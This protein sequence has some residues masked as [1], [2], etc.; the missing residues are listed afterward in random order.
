MNR[1]T[2]LSSAQNPR[3]YGAPPFTVAVVHGG[4]GAAGETAPAARELSDEFGVIEPLQTAFTIQGQ[5]EELGGM[6]AAYGAL[7]VNV[8]GY[9]WG[10]WLAIMTAARYPE[11]VRGLILVSSGPFEERYTAD[12]EETRLSRLSPDERREAEALISVFSHG[13]P[14]KK[15]AAFALIGALLSKADMYDPLPDPCDEVECRADIFEGI[16]SE[17]AEL[18]RSGRLLETARQIQCPVLAIHGDY[19]PHPSEG[20]RGPLSAIF[21]D[22]RF[23]LLDRCGH[24]PWRERNAHD[25]FFR[26][27]R[28]ELRA[29]K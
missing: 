10:A 16:W 25:A 5:V 14:E 18:R 29:R 19:D 15:N 24:T 11:R 8:I 22:L 21:P 2:P 28:E 20:V 12:M 4:P 7:P 23:I 3:L 1:A 9:S 27:I 6:L 26:T 13:A 17:A